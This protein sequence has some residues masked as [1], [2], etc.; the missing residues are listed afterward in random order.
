VNLAIRP[1]PLHAVAKRDVPIVL[2][3]GRVPE[4]LQNLDCFIKKSE[5]VPKFLWPDGRQPAFWLEDADFAEVGSQSHDEFTLL[6][7]RLHSQRRHAP[8]CD[9]EPSVDLGA[10]R[11]G[12]IALLCSAEG[13]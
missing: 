3:S 6:L 11:G 7:S 5:P 4:S 2:Y 9:N 8:F 10:S 12:P 1:W 13:F